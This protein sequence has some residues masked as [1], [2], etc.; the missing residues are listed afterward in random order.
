MTDF[1]HLAYDE[2]Q[3]L[4][5]LDIQIEPGVTVR[6]L[7]T[8]EQC[9]S[10]ILKL[11]LQMSRIQSQIARAEADP[12]S[13]QPGWRTRAQGAMRWKKRA[14]KAINV[15][16]IALAKQAAGTSRGT[17]ILR[18]IREDIGEALFEAYVE[19]AKMRYPEAFA[20]GG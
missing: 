6:D 3:S 14:I 15:Y 2:I 9:T 8:P 12:T 11:D 18:V 4:D 7:K 19:T 20:E 1:P 5:P 10:A 17:L 13:V 16:S